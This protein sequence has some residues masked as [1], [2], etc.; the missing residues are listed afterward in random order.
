M[1]TVSVVI[2]NWNTRALLQACLRSLPCEAEGLQLEVIVVDNGST[3]DSAAMVEAEFP[4]VRLIRNA[5]NVGFVRANNQG[6]ATASGEFLFMLNSDTEVRPGAIERLVEV[7]GSDRAIGAAGPRL[8]NSDGTVQESFGPFPSAVFRLFPSRFES[9]YRHRIEQRAQ[10][11]TADVDW[12]AGAA[13]M[14]RR[15]VLERVGPLD[16]RYYMWYDDLDWAQKLRQAG[17]QRVFAPDAVIVH[18]GRQTGRR[19]D[20]RELAAQLW[21]SEYTYLRLH[22]GR[23]GVCLAMLARMAKA[24]VRWPLPGQREEAGWRLRYHLGRFGRFCFRKM[25]QNSTSR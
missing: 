15:E 18:H 5:D 7:V 4:Q 14:T 11:G 8:L 22:H 21:D 20:N 23:G 17:Y 2:V 9:G 1:P 13:V 10:D 12:L 25:P 24:L 3:D 19:L 6:L 16:E